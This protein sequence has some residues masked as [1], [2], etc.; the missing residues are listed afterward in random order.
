MSSTDASR[1]CASTLP[2]SSSWTAER[3]L[4]LGD[5]FFDRP[6]EINDP[7]AD[8]CS[9]VERPL[10]QLLQTNVTNRALCGEEL[11]FS[12]RRASTVENQY[13]ASDEFDWVVI[14]AGINNLLCLDDSTCQGTA[15]AD[16]CSEASCTFLDGII[17]ANAT[18]G[19]MH[20]LVA[21]VRANGAHVVVVGYP[22][23]VK[24]R[25]AQRDS[26][27]QPTRPGWL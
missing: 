13:R 9:F 14:V 27:V 4:L 22:L 26:I 21:R 19:A 17:N 11:A 8:N 2:G 3:V 20:D 12:S 7:E 1:A 6:R 16:R 25:V 23:G 15:L 10:S 5:S 18:A 24:V